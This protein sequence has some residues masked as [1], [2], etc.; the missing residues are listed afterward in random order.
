MLRISILILACVLLAA[1]GDSGMDSPETLGKT[2]VKQLRDNDLEGFIKTIVMSE[3]DLDCFIKNAA[4]ALKQE[5]ARAKEKLNEA[6]EEAEYEWEKARTKGAEDGIDWA[7]IE[8]VG[9]T[10]ETKELESFLT[11]DIFVMFKYEDRKYVIRV[12][13]VFMCEGEWFAADGLRYKGMVE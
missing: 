2:L 8:Y 7:E 4:N 6:V 10:A 11:G 13:D 5:A 12:D 9:A 1:C 3:Q